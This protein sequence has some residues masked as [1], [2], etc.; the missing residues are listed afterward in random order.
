MVMYVDA[1]NHE[2]TQPSSHKCYDEYGGY[3]PLVHTSE[4]RCIHYGTIIADVQ[5]LELDF[6]NE[7]LCFI[8]A[9]AKYRKFPAI[10]MSNEDYYEGII[11]K[12]VGHGK[13]FELN[14]LKKVGKI[15]MEAYSAFAMR[16]FEVFEEDILWATAAVMVSNNNKKALWVS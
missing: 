6:I 14:I 5:H 7:T 15:L 16:R 4:N 2:H 8:N 3:Y 12:Y 11:S 9:V 13:P 10:I 1:L